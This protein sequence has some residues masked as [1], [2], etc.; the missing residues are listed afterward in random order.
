MD[1][2]ADTVV[3]LAD[4]VRTDGE[5][6]VDVVVAEEVGLIEV[7]W[8]V[9]DFDKILVGVEEGNDVDRIL[10]SNDVGL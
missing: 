7:T 3:S 8:I 5:A 1:P 4:V 6:V 10:G 9:G 2:Q